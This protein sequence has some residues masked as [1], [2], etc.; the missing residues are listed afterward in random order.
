MGKEF[1]ITPRTV[2]QVETA[3][4]RI[5][6]QVPHPDSV[7]TLEQLRAFEPQSMRGQPP[8]V[9]D[10]AEDI[11]VYDKYGN[12]WLDWSSGVLVA[13]CGHG[14]QE[15]RQAIIDQVNSG[16]LHNYVFPSEERAELEEHLLRFAPKGLEKVFLLTTGS[17]ATECAI[18]LARSYGIRKGGRKKIGIVGAERGFHGRTLGAQQ[19]GGIPGQKSW[20]VNEDAA[21]VQVPFPDGYWTEDTSF[22]LFLSTLKQKGLAPENVA[23]VI[24]EAYQGVGPDFAPVDYIRQLAAWCKAN[25]ALLIFDEVQSGFGRTGKFWAFEHY[26]VIPDAICCGKGISSSLPLSAVLGRAEIM[27]EF[28]P[29]SMTSTHTG[30]PVCCAAALASLKKIADEK[31][32][33]NAARLGTILDAGLRQIQQRHKEFIGHYTCRGLVAGLQMTTRNRK[34]ANH[35]LA[36]AIVERCFQK[37][38]LFFSPVGAWGQTVKIAP[39]LTITEAAIREGL[40]VLAEAVDE[41]IAAL[42]S[43]PT[44]TSPALATR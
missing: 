37:G 16:L 7:K 12:K 5:I 21:I 44:T 38:L 43:P 11:F 8:L 1:S 30:N 32:V 24:F 35:D 10:R 23:G 18:K 31:L 39:P 25:D 19:A 6:S 33:E 14:P 26:G 2:P 40:E 22:D 34:E 3:H 9:W 36:H 42:P 28:P 29:G 17:E 4:R 15:V 27:D 20:I 41:S 13:N